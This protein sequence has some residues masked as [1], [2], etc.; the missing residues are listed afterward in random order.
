M[1]IYVAS[2]WRNPYQPEV[3]EELRSQGHEVYDFRNP[4]NGSGGFAWSDIDPNWESWT[5]EQYNEALKHPIA[6]DGFNSDFD[7]MKWA[8]A[9]VMVL[10]CGRSANTEAG[11]M[12]GHGKLVFVL[13]PI[14]QEPELMYKIYDGVF[15][16]VIDLCNRLLQLEVVA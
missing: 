11:W 16:N 5:T 7:G 3:V 2:S 1:K 4:P 10:P 9:C 12:K 14:K 6:I 13:S 15:G 8:D